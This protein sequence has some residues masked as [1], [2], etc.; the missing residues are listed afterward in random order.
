M[1]TL[2]L[3]PF[4]SFKFVSLISDLTIQIDISEWV[5]DS[6]TVFV[7]LKMKGVKLIMFEEPSSTLLSSF[8]DFN[9]SS[10]RKLIFG[11]KD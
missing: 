3:L 4:Y 9:K 1:T 7:L 10:T 2:R 11:S 5:Y 8:E 6:L